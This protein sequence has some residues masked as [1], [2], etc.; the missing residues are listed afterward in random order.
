MKSSQKLQTKK[1]KGFKIWDDLADL[2]AAVRNN[3]VRSFYTLYSSSPDNTFVTY[4][5]VSQSDH[6]HYYNPEILTIFH[7]FYMHL[8]VCMFNKMQFDIAYRFK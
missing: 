6:W 2:C 1:K 8:F 3:R 7:E 5:A 4:S